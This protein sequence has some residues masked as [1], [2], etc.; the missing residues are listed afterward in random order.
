MK[1][2]LLI[3]CFSFLILPSCYVG[4]FVIYNFSDIRDYKKFPSKPLHRSPNAFQYA[5]IKG[6]ESVKL[7]KTRKG[8]KE[9]PFEYHLQKSGTV[10]FTIIRNDTVIYD[11]VRPK[12]EQSSI[13]PSFSMAK[14]FISALI[15]IAIDEG[16]IKNTS[17]PITNYIAYLDKNTF[18]KITIQHLLDMESGIKFGE[19]YI[20]PFSDVA[21]Y[22]YGTNLKKYLKKLKIKEEPGKTFEYMSLNTQLLALILET[23][24]GKSPTEYLQE[25]IWAPLGMEY[26]ASWSIDSKKHGTEKAFCCINATS[27]DFAKFGSLYLHEG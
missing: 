9:Q 1:K 13:V 17:E 8:K 15:G 14:S 20:S 22:Y 27:R 6:N 16:K 18:G 3:A 23:A 11:W 24:V 21:K 2:L 5:E 4:R 26:D 12:Y 7:P 19:S 10:A 25:K